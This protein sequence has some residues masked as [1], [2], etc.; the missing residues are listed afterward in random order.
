MR[1]TENV[2]FIQSDS[3]W[4]RGD[5]RVRQNK[6]QASKEIFKMMVFRVFNHNGGDDTIDRAE[7]IIAA[8]QKEAR[9]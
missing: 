4:K 9:Q 7:A 6:L 8:R 5:G 1:R 3:V 2:F